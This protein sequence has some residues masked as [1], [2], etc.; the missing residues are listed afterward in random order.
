MPIGQCISSHC[1]GFL[2]LYVVTVILTKEVHGSRS[3]L[4]PYSRRDWI[5]F[6][7]S[8]SDYVIRAIKPTG[9]PMM[10]KAIYTDVSK[11]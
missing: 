5:L 3:H 4:F 11:L 10:Q 2:L 6:E 7:S 9:F 8:T 1:M